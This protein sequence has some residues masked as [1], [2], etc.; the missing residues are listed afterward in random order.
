MQKK[1][2]PIVKIDSQDKTTDI[3]NP[4]DVLQN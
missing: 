1:N 2:T 4:L 3:T